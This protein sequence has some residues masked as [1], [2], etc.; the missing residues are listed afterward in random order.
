GAFFNP[1]DGVKAALER[2]E[3]YHDAGIDYVMMRFPIGPTTEA[4]TKSYTEGMRWFAQEV[5]PAL[6]S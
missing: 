6:G 1:D 4:T 2:M 5:R 3:R